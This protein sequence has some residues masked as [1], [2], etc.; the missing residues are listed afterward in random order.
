MGKSRKIKKRFRK[1]SEN[2]IKTRKLIE[3]NEKLLKELKKQ[4][5]Y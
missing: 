1:N 3:K 2:K 4:L 5:S